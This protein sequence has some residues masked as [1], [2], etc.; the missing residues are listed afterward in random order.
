MHKW[1]ILVQFKISFHIAP[2]R[3]QGVVDL[4]GEKDWTHSLQIIYCISPS[5]SIISHFNHWD[6]LAWY[7]LWLPWQ[8]IFTFMKSCAY[9]FLSRQTYFQIANPLSIVVILPLN[10]LIH[11]TSESILHPHLNSF[12]FFFEIYIS[13][14]SSFLLVKF[15]YRKND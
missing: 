8:R 9:V 14:L 12:N 10:I 4:G 3:G 1:S 6:I 15:Y 5:F 11:N 7:I 2:K 13:K